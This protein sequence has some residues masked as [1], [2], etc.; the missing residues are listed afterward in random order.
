MRYSWK[1]HGRMTGCLSQQGEVEGLRFLESVLEARAMTRASNSTEESDVNRKST[2]CQQNV[3]RK[4]TRFFVLEM[5]EEERNRVLTAV[6]GGLLCG[7]ISTDGKK[8]PSRCEQVS[9][10]APFTPFTPFLPLSPLLPLLLSLLQK[11][12]CEPSP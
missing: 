11:F 2:E 8:I 7:S 1:Q 5:R 3:N 4:S 12:K 6:G 10:S 9:Y